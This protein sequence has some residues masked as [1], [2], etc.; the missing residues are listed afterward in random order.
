MCNGNSNLR[1]AIDGG[2]ATGKTTVA[3][4]IAKHLNL[5]YFNTGSMYRLITFFGLKNNLLGD[6]KTLINKI[7]NEKIYLKNSNLASSIKFNLIDLDS[8]EVV[9]NVSQVAAI[10]EIRDFAKTFQVKVGMQKNV[11]LEGRDIGTIIMPDADFK[12]FLKVSPS[13]AARR[14]QEQNLKNN[15]SSSYEEILKSILMRNE[16]DSKRKFAPLVPAK[17][18]YI[19]WTDKKTP[20]QIVKEIEDII[21]GKK[22]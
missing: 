2:A 9:N 6:W 21:Y 5:T 10:K 8:L 15:I 11:L 22:N 7:A 18:A 14:R 3:K 17:D 19:I 20:S 13:E 16:Y 4:L 1:I 12:F